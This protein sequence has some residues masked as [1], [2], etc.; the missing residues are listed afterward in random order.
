MIHCGTHEHN[1]KDGTSKLLTDKTREMVSKVLGIDRH[2]GARKVQMCVAKEIVMT[3]LMQDG[4]NRNI[5]GKQEFAT[6]AEDMGPLV[7]DN[8]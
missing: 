2:A 8:W 7:H 3:T 1:V 4:G 6:I 5:I